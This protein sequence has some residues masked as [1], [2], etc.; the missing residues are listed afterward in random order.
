MNAMWFMLFSTFETLAIYSLI[1]TLLR[2]KTTAYIWQALF[3][4]ILAN[5]QSYIMRNELHMDFLA[6][7]ITV[8]IYV[9]LFA[10]II[11]IPVIWS[12]ICTII[13]YM[14]YALIQT[15]Y[16]TTI[17]GSIDSVQTVLSHGYILQI[18]SAATGLLLSWIMYRLGLGFRYDLE[19]LRFR[20]EHILLIALIIVVLVL[21]A[22]LF[23]MNKL[24]LDL[25]FF[26]VTFGIFLYYAFHT[27]ER[28][29]FD[30]GKISGPD[31]GRDQ[32]PGSRP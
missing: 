23:Y 11:K 17:F 29:T 16:L 22:I 7:L 2:Y 26:G 21:I 20:F 1:M 5:I 32:A 18:L 30:R 31:G 4:M 28:D 3:F 9:F 27:E 25:L 13:G 8:L 19:K 6:P 15:I 12:A 14:L 24:W 10:A